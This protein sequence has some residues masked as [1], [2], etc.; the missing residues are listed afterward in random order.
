MR[1]ITS[2]RRDVSANSIDLAQFERVCACLGEAAVDPAQWPKIMEQ[3]CRAVG[4][5]GGLMLQADVRTPDV[6]RTPSA[7]EGAR[8]YFDNNWH[9]RDTRA[10]RGVPLLLRGAPVVVDQDFMTPDDLRRDSFYNECLARV[11]MNWFAGVGFRAGSALWALTFQRGAKEGLFEPD[12]KQV[13]ATLSARLTEVA[14]LSTTVGR[15]AL[16]AAT[17]AL[18]G[19]RQ[20]AVAIDRRGRVLDINSV[21]HD[22]FDDELCVRSSQISMHDKEAKRRLDALALKLSVIVDT[23]PLAAEPIV[24]R[25]RNA[26]P[27][28]IRVLP[29]P[30]AARNPFLGAR[31]LLTLTPLASKPAPAA[32]LLVET[33]GLTRAEARLASIIAT[34][35]SPEQAA[36][37]LEISRQ[38]VR[39][40]LKAVFAKTRTHRQGELIALLARL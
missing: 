2:G 19:I 26:P 10:L 35:A 9:A 34:G 6:P 12:E 29:V 38:T 8:Y 40:Q 16:S 18:N 20:P 39:T 5:N 31:A 3:L 22:L 27:V 1:A 14:T 37:Q 23:T 25:R 17:N 21:A 11:G 32:R 13:L 30:A 15:I 7:E 33:F 24:V 4:A 28:V 36:E